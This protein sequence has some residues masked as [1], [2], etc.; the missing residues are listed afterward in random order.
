M[1]KE[2]IHVSAATVLLVVLIFLSVSGAAG[3]VI[4]PLRSFVNFLSWP[5]VK[6]FEK[7]E[8]FFQL[9]F[10]LR[11]LVQQNEILN[12]QVEELSSEI[13]VLE[14]ARIENKF[15]REA[16]GFFR[17]TKLELVPTEI[18]AFD[19]LNVSQT[20]TIDRG[21]ND[22]VEVGDPVIVAKGILVAVV[23]DV[24]DSTSEARLLTSSA[25]SVN[26]EVLPSGASGIV[27]GEHGLGLV[28][29]LI[30][31]NEVI[32]T[33]DSVITSGLG[34]GFPKNLLIGQ[35]GEVDSGGPELFQ[36]AS[37]VPAANLKHNKTV[38]VVKE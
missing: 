24:F 3:K 12:R 20:F 4:D 27:R 38:F 37:I 9:T 32:K 13:A 5:L 16:L 2:L 34:G 14:R 1:S 22:G 31:Q 11:V 15:L 25:V 36:K 35:I 29:D 21:K 26:A 7:F 8:N 17:E 6:I 28:F 33:G 23:S 19:I 10:G 18:I 30:S